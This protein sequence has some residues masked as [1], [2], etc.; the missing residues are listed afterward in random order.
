MAF[1]ISGW[2]CRYART[3]SRR[4]AGA[5]QHV[6][7]LALGALLGLGQDH[8]AARQRVHLGVALDLE[9]RVE[10]LRE[11][12]EHPRHGADR[13]R[14]GHA[15]VRRQLADHVGLLL[16]IGP[17]GLADQHVALAAVEPA[18]EVGGGQPSQLELARHLVRRVA[19]RPPQAVDGEAEDALT[20][21]AQ[22]QLQP[23]ALLDAAVVLEPL[24]PQAQQ[25]VHPDGDAGR[26]DLAA[27]GLEPAVDVVVRITLDG[28]QI[29]LAGDLH[30]GLHAQPVDLDLRELAVDLAHGP[31]EVRRRQVPQHRLLGRRLLRPVPEHLV[32]V[33]DALLDDRGRLAGQ[34]LVGPHLVLEVLHEVRAEDAPQA[35]ERHRQAQ[36]E[37]VAHVLVQVVLGHEE[38]AERLQPAVTQRQLVALVILAEPAGAAGAGREVDELLA[39]VGH[40]GLLGFLLQEVDQVARREAGRAALADVG[41]LAAGQEVVLGGHR[42]DLRLVPGALQHGLDDSFDAPV[43]AAEQDGGRVPLSAGERLGGVRAVV[44]SCLRGH[45]V[46]R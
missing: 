19:H 14:V 21:P 39:D 18:V 5:G 41:D 37:A 20:E 7:E 36:L 42:E 26:V 35:A 27:L 34:H 13:H 40:A 44:L 17:D 33:F 9:R 43:Q 22:P 3:S 24:Q 8:L 45:S 38:H 31:R 15:G 30:L 2:A 29:E 11:L 32:E 6:V 10:D 4:E 1:F 46:L 16:L 28:L 23:R 12:A 25:V